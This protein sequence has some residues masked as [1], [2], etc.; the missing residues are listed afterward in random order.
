MP[1]RKHD[2]VEELILRQGTP[3]SYRDCEQ[4]YRDLR[5]YI[6][7]EEPRNI[8]HQPVLM[9]SIWTLVPLGMRATD[10]MN[11]QRIFDGIQ[12]CPLNVIDLRF[13]LT[14]PNKFDM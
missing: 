1:L 10:L 9:G 6:E 5:S 14:N 12:A 2:L 3:S 4:A 11:P 13:D 8:L 7:E